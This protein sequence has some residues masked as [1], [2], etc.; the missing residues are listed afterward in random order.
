MNNQTLIRRSFWENKSVVVTG[1]TGFKGSWLTICLERLGAK[2]LGISLEPDSNPCLFNAA[3]ISNICNSILCDIRDYKKLENILSEF[4]PEIVFHLAAQPL[5]GESYK[6]PIKTYSTNLMGSINILEVSRSLTS[7][8]SLVIVTTDKVYKNKEWC[9]PYRENDE[10]GGF[11]PYSS[12]K[13]ATEIAVAS[14]RDSFFK[15]KNL[16]ITTARAGNVIGGGD[17][18]A[19]RLIP[20]AIR[21]WRT[22]EELVIRHPDFIRPWQHVLE[23]IYG[24]LLLAQATYGNISLNGA[25]NFGPQNNDF[26]SVKRLLEI[27]SD[28]N[29]RPS[30]KYL[31]EPTYHESN[32]LVL[33]YSHSMQTLGYKPRWTIRKSIENTISWYK[34]YYSGENVMISCLDDINEFFRKDDQI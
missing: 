18:A 23:P 3:K 27:A 25:Y 11:D 2:V 32:N 8:K 12:S 20:D 1:H 13:A 26:I 10:L 5:V 22:N 28:Y 15:D 19:D 24:Y 30:I 34:K 16:S 31:E 4:N 17:W 33:D 7:L 9:Y 21:A 29:M 14:Y 6:D